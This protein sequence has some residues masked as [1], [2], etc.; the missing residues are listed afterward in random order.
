MQKIEVNN[1]FKLG[2]WLISIRFDKV[3]DVDLQTKLKRLA[4]KIFLR[5]KVNSMLLNLYKKIK[6]RPG[7]SGYLESKK[8]FELKCYKLTV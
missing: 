4:K 2:N 6:F 7:N 5:I 1:N 3:I 8:K